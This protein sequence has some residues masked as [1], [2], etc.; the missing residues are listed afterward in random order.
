MGGIKDS[1]ELVTTCMPNPN[2][3]EWLLIF[4]Y[5]THMYL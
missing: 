3:K 5:D 2:K 1:P 4:F